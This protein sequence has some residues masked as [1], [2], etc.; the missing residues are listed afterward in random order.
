MIDVVSGNLSQ[1]KDWD[2]IWL[3]SHENE[4]TVQELDRPIEKSSQEELKQT[5]DSGYATS[6]WEQTKVV[7]QRM[8]IALWRNSDYVKNKLIL[9]IVTAPLQRIYLLDDQRY[10]QWSPGTAVHRLQFHIRRPGSNQPAPTSLHRAPQN[11]RRARKET[12]HLF[13]ESIHH[14][15]N[16]L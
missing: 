11:L 6:L 7:T 1:G 12:P 3:Q 10:C 14:D 5:D 15:P 9:H 2:K 4:N 16:C 13:L 8:S